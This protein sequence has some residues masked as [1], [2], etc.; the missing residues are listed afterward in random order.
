E[1]FAI[2]SFSH[3]S[4]CEIQDGFIVLE[5]LTPFQSYQLSYNGQPYQSYTSNSLGEITLL[6]LSAGTYH[7]ITID[8]GTCSSSV[9]DVIVLSDPPGPAIDAG[10]DVVLC[11]GD[12][13][14]LS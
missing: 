2:Q 12:E 5:G 9:N 7:N 13:L 4:E 3:P 1:S 14:V 6:N 11:Y 8:F 10:P